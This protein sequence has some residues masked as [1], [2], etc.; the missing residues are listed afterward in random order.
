MFQVIRQEPRN[1]EPYR[2]V[3]DIYN[4]LNKP[5]KSLQYGLLA[6]HLNGNRTSAIEWADLGNYAFKLNRSEEAAACFG[7]G[8]LTYC[9]CIFFN[10]S[11]L[12]KPDK[13]KPIFACYCLE[14]EKVLTLLWLK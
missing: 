12:L 1:P 11:V 4:D 8:S 7:R 5:Q 13:S 10:C 6:A 3:A 2:Q 14:E 9:K